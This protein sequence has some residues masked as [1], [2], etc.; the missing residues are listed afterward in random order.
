LLRDSGFGRTGRD[1]FLAR[2]KV[3]SQGNLLDIEG[4]FS[5]ADITWL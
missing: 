5:A 4:G 3:I 1:T 2:H